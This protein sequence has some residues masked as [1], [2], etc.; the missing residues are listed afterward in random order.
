MQFRLIDANELLK[1]QYCIDDSATL[2]TRNVVNVDDINDAPTIIIEEEDIKQITLHV[3]KVKK[4]VSKID[5][6]EIED[7]K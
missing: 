4:H 6:E 3:Q 1:N 2:S 7:E 5:L